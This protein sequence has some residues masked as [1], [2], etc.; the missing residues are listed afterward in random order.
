MCCDF[1]L[2]MAGSRFSFFIMNI[3]L[4]VV[5]LGLINAIFDL[6]RLLFYAEFILL[7]VLMLAAL[8]AVALIYSEL[9]FGWTLM[10]FVFVIILIDLFFI[11]LVGAP[12]L[13]LLLQMGIVSLVGF[14][15]SLANMQAPEEAKEETAEPNVKSEFKPG[16]YV[17][18]KTGAKFHAPK[19][20][21]AKKIKKKNQ[22]WFNSAEEAKKAGY[23]TD[24]C[25]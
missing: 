22:V 15:I 4:L 10:S 16:K 9:R 13:N 25:V 6:H 11:Y 8:I 21:W 14:V 20:D 18:S 17:A 24:D 19:C 2:K 5:F 7:G 23:K 3:V 1:F 12:N